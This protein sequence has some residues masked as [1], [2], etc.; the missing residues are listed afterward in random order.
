MSFE[1][2]VSPSAIMNPVRFDLAAI[3]AAM[4]WPDDAAARDE[5][6]GAVTVDEGKDH[7]DSMSE[8]A[9]RHWA[10]NAASVPR[11]PDLQ[12]RIGKRG[13]HGRIAGIITLRATI[14]TKADPQNAALRKI[15]ADIS[16]RLWRT[17]K[18]GPR[19]MEN[20][21]GPIYPFRPVAH[22]WAAHSFHIIR[23]GDEAMPCVPERLPDFLATA[24]SI[25]FLAEK[26]KT[27]RSATTIMRP[28]EA[29]K[30]PTDVVRILAEITP[31]IYS[32]TSPGIGS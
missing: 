31:Q 32:S 25:R 27:P 24:E 14:L 1:I 8:N 21:E 9:L 11:L 28:G 4:L 29:A 7:I 17:L 3:E 6:V 22:L 10:H 15:H 13:I 20:K 16:K 30:L 12:S 18:I 23:G 2:P 19:T 5:W 26:T